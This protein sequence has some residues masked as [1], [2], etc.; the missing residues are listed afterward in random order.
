MPRLELTDRF[1]AGAKAD[2]ETSQ[3]DY[4]D[5]R[6]PGLAL[7]ISGA[8][9]KS[10]SFVFTAPNGKRAR[11]SL[12]HY[13]T[14]S[15]SRARTEARQA[16]GH[17]GDGADPRA[18]MQRRGS[19]AMTVAELVAVYMADPERAKLRSIN[20]VGRRLEKNALP[21]IGAVPL[22]QLT[23]RDILD[24]TERVMRRGARTEAWHVFKD[25]RAVLRWGVANL[26]LEHTPT[27][28]MTAPGGFTPASAR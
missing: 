19:A 1:V 25:L 9:R 13:P 24:V 7:R 28:G 11:M 21:K 27:E 18:A 15:L 16:R 26:Y 14:M 17:S 23:K 2:K 22:A 8:G 5:S 3:T 10:W 4:F 20:E 12:G 6:T